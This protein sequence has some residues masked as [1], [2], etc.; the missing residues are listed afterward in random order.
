MPRP[1]IAVAGIAHESNTHSTLR[2]EL[3][4]FRVLRGEEII[5]DPTLASVGDVDWAP[6]LVAYA[7]PNGM[8]ARGAYEALKAELLD[9]LNAELPVDG[10]LLRL[11]GAMEVESLG[12]G[13]TDLLVAIRS[14][15]GSDPLLA[16]R[17]DL[18]ANLSPV[19]AGATDILTAHRTAP[20]VDG[21]ETLARTGRHLA[22]AVREGLRPR[23]CLV[24]LPLRLPGE[25]AVTDYE[26]AQA[27]YARLPSLEGQPGILDASILIG[28][29][30]T[31]SVHAGVGALLVAE[32]VDHQAEAL[33]L[34]QELAEDIWRRRGEFGPDVPTGELSAVLERA[35]GSPQ[36]PVVIA[37]SG[38]NPGAGGAGDTTVVLEALL[39]AGATGALV[40]GIADRAAVD[41]CCLAGEGRPV[42]VTLGGRLD[43]VNGRPLELRAEVERVVPDVLAVAR[44]EGVRIII[45][46]ARSQLSEE[47]QYGEA[48]VDPSV[49]RI[50]V[51]KCGYMSEYLKGIAG[52]RLMA[53]TPG[54]TTLEPA[55]TVD[56]AIGWATPRPGGWGG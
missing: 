18:H 4:D 29:A 19:A 22:R 21:R 25:F 45:T 16:G 43:T 1:R 17:L 53:L 26:P 13:E 49:Y 24:K 54:F 51:V 40:A 37:D 10:V 55:F 32:S 9:R 7:A 27:L 39:A 44:A 14:L 6:T 48:G 28:C 35:L 20:H 5:A 2:T 42:G 23:N 31:D 3:S 50:V 33:S 34:A 46:A 15:V 11:H 36:R 30:W 56:P 47:S 12:D 38:D 52:D 8:V 41:A